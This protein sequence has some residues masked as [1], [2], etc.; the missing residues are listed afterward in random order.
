[1]MT[2]DQMVLSEIDLGLGALC[3]FADEAMARN[4][5]D[6]FRVIDEV[7]RAV[8]SNSNHRQAAGFCAYVLL[9]HRGY[10]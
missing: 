9:R 8:A 10:L 1:M 6:V 4:G 7:S 5:N 3:R 2:D